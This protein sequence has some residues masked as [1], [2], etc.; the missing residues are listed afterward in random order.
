MALSPGGTFPWWHFSLVA[1][2][3]SAGLVAHGKA[4]LFVFDYLNMLNLSFLIKEN[5]PHDPVARLVALF[6]W[7]HF[8]LV[9]LLLVAGLVAHGKA[10]GYLFLTI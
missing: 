9:A 7:W 5:V 8:S 4:P 10:Y 6:T 1:L 3:L 2:L